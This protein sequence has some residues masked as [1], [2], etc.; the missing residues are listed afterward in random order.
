MVEAWRTPNPHTGTESYLH[1][2]N[3]LGHL[4]KHPELA[5]HL[6]ATQATAS[7]PDV[8]VEVNEAIYKYKYGYGSQNT[9][10]LWLLIIEQ[11]GEDGR[12]FV[13]SAYFTRNLKAGYPIQIYRI[14]LR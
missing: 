9:R 5:G 13:K 8:V 10:N 14:P 6:D 7:D 4:G 2:S 1:R 12:H 11:I 3:W